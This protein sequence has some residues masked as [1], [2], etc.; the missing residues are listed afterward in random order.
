MKGR[1]F[2]LLVFCICFLGSMLV[3]DWAKAG[4]NVGVSSNLGNATGAMSLKTGY[5]SK[6]NAYSLRA[7]GF[8]GENMRMMNGFLKD[9]PT[10]VIDTE[11]EIQFSSQPDSAGSLDM[12]E[13]LGVVSSDE[14]E[15][16]D[17]AVGAGVSGNSETDFISQG[18]TD[19]SGVGYAV[20]A[21][22][23]GQFMAGAEAMDSEY[24]GV[25]GL[26]GSERYRYH[27]RARGDY[28]YMGEFIIS[29][30]E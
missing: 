1:I 15:C 20:M 26:V 22:G 5:H 17:A 10:G 9:A 23:R 3:A 7:R 6:T 29:K 19:A 8:D 4:M 11:T 27:L 21:S 28:Q 18:T 14:D 12:E 30:D 25:G 16:F 2:F 24:D 13:K